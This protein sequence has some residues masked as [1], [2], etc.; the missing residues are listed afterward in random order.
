MWNVFGFI[1][2]VACF[3]AMCGFAEN[4]FNVVAGICAVAGVFFSSINC[5]R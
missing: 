5:L 3:T 4:G 2:A 1:L